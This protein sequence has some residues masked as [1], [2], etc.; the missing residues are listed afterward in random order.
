MF[1]Q[2]K[3]LEINYT[4]FYIIEIKST[5]RVIAA[6]MQNHLDYYQLK[7]PQEGS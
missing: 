3:K 2:I 1:W 4:C 6:K 7:T 5:V